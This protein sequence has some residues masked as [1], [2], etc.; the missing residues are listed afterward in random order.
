MV[1]CDLC[2]KQNC[3]SCMSGS[4]KLIRKH[5]CRD[6][7]ERVAKEQNEKKGFLG[8]I[9]EKNPIKILFDRYFLSMV[10]FLKIPY[11]H[12]FS[13]SSAAPKS[14]LTSPFFPTLDIPSLTRSAMDIEPLLSD[15][16]AYAQEA[17]VGKWTRWAIFILL[18][19]PFSLIQFVFD[20]KKITDGAKFN[21]EAVPW[22]QVALL[23]F[24]GIIFSFFISGYMVRIYRGTKPAPDFTGWTEL[25][26]DGIKLAVV[27]FLWVLPLFV[28]LA[29]IAALAIAF[30]VVSPGAEMNWTFLGILLLLVLV[31]IVLLVCVVL[32]GILGAVRFARTGS[33]REGIHASAILV[34]IRTIGWV[35]Y[36]ISLIV[37]AVVCVI[38]AIIT[39]ILSLI[40][41]I[42]WVLVMIV[43][44]FFS[45]FFAR[46]FTQ[47]YDHGESKTEPPIVPPVVPLEVPPAPA[48]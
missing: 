38:Y 5:Y 20:P 30:F 22:A 23:V 17:L 36:L 7:C 48:V 19:L 15:S 25:F 11:C 34:T 45:I 28:I 21:W 9:K 39:A 31:E 3:S 24:V 1:T 42:G 13:P 41:Y 47:V 29:A 4:G 10:T 12:L 8:K 18:A 26:V 16:F 33:I 37:I 2:G 46:Y 44:P 6:T 40:P 43:A 32:F 35:S 27:W 14:P